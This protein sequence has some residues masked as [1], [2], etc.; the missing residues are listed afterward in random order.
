MTYGLSFPSPSI[1]AAYQNSELQRLYS[2]YKQEMLYL[3]NF[4]L[5]TLRGYDEAH[6]R[7]LR[8]VGVEIPTEN[9]LSRFV[10]GMRQAGLSATTCNISIRAMNAYLTWLKEKGRIPEKFSNGKTF[11]ISKLPEE[12]RHFKVFS[13]EEIGRIL[14]FKPKTKTQWR[15]F[16]FLTV[17]ADTG[18]R[19]NECLSL[20]IQDI[21][22]DNLSIHVKRGKQKKQRLVRISFG[23]RN[24]LFKWMNKFRPQKIFSPWLWSTSNGSQ[25]T[26]RNAMR[27]FL[28]LL[29]AVGV[30]KDSIDGCFHSFRRKFARNLHKDGHSLQ[31]I[32]QAM[33]HSTI[34]MT[35]HYV[36]E[37]DPEEILKMQLKSSLVTKFGK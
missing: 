3:K 27:D 21:D 23:C 37:I 4:S 24:V 32:K 34:T 9:N 1:E 11:K 6:Q 31:S 7:W 14:S 25:L 35:S 12:K 15:I 30:K 2:E 13:D 10:I 19:A 17:I 5:R 26:Y 18:M 29:K 20:E 16:T 33:G 28:D 22:L 8:F 36:D